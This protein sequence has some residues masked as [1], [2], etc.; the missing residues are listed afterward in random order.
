MLRK[1]IS[2]CTL[3]NRSFKRTSRPVS[4]GLLPITRRAQLRSCA[5][6]V[7]AIWRPR[8]DRRWTANS[9]IAK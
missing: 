8:D 6:P 2:R 9:G 7:A 5:W 4:L 1:P 3:I